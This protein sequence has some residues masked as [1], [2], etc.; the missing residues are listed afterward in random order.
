M[1]TQEIECPS[2]GGRGGLMP[3]NQYL[4]AL[5]EDLGVGHALPRIAI[6]RAEQNL[7]EVALLAWLC[8]AAADV[9][10]E[11]LVAPFAHRLMSAQLTRNG[12]PWCKIWPDD[13]TNQEGLN[14][15]DRIA[16]ELD[17]VV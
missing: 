4:H 17:F 1:P 14:H 8:P 16:N 9:P 2:Q 6:E 12:E 11:D 7:Q 15:R 13:L 3:C 5:A 10:E